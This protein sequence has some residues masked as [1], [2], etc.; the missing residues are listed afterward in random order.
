M[1]FGGSSVGNG[2]SIKNVVK[3]ISSNVE[4]GNSLTVVVS[5]LSGITDSLVEITD[6]SMNGDSK[7]VRDFLKQIL[8]RHKTVS[9]EAMNKAAFIKRAIK[10]LDET[11]GELE[12][13]L[14][15]V[16]N[17]REVTSRSRDYILSFGERMS[18]IIL[19][20]ALEEAG[21]KV[22]KFTGGE[23][24]I[25]TDDHFG[26]AAPL[27]NVTFY[28]VKDRLEP[29]LEKGEIPVVAGFIAYTQDGLTTTLGRG[30]SDYTATILGAALGVNEVWVWTDV[31]GL[32]TADPKIEPNARTIPMLSYMEAMEMAYFGARVIHPRALEP[33]VE[34]EIPIR[35]RNTFSPKNEGTIIVNEEAV[36]D[37]SVVKSIAIIRDIAGITISGAG[38]IGVPGVAAKVFGLLGENKVNVLMISQSSSEANISFMILRS[39]LESTV[40]MLELALLGHGVVKEIASESDVNIIAIVGAGMKG[41]LGVAARVFKAV[42]EEGINVRMIAQGS[43]ELN[44]SFVVKESDGIRAVRKLHKEFQLG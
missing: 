24:G 9:K 31:D 26:E 41:T 34:K 30:A 38:M 20:S 12:R 40:D 17:L 13:I 28:Q 19:C 27:M 25:V 2:K 32:M 5:A 16:S 42:A 1:K 33:A 4:A 36:S 43:S 22:R 21:L 35:I 6:K 39:Q 23:A 7:T 29:L 10:E 44:I 11:A 3:I 18:T 15:S 37:K 8:T 14:I